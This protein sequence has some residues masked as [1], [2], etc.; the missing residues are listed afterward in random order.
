MSQNNYGNDSIEVLSALEANRRSPELL[1]GDKGVKGARHTIFEIVGNA[2]DEAQSGFGDVIEINYNE[3]TNVVSVR[4]YGRG[5]PLGW[6]EDKVNPDRSAYNWYNIFCTQHA[7]G[8]YKTSY[9]DEL[10]GIQDWSEF[11]S[12]DFPYIYSVGTYGIGASATQQT[13]DFLRVVSIRD[14]ERTEMNFK[15]GLPVV[16]AEYSGEKMKTYPPTVTKSDEPTGTLV[17][18]RPSAD[19]FYETHIG[20]QFLQTICESTAY[21]SKVH[22]VLNVTKADGTVKTYDYPVGTLDDF[23]SKQLGTSSSVLAKPRS[24]SFFNHGTFMTGSM[25]NRQEKIWVAEG[26]ISYAV[27]RDLGNTTAYYNGMRMNA[28]VQFEGIQKALTRFLGEVLPTR[29]RRSEIEGILN[30]VVECKSNHIDYNGADKNNITSGWMRQ[31]V[32]DTLYNDLKEGYTYKTS[33]VLA[34]VNLVK[35]RIENR[36]DDEERKQIVKEIKADSKP[37]ARVSDL[38]AFTPSSNYIKGITLAKKDTDYATRVCNPLE[39][40]YNENFYVEGDSAGGSAEAGRFREFQCITKTTGKPVNSAKVSDTVALSKQFIKSLIQINGAGMYIP[41]MPEESTYDASLEKIDKHII[42]TDADKDGYH[43]RNLI[44]LAFFYFQPEV[45][46][47]GRLFIA[48]APLY[49]V[50][51]TDGSKDFALTLNERDLKIKKSGK[52]VKEISRLKGLG[53][54]ESEDLSLACMNPETRHLVQVLADPYDAELQQ[55]VMEMFGLSS[56]TR[57]S[58]FSILLGVDIIEAE[59]FAK[60]VAKEINADED[61]VDDLDSDFIFV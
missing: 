8:K 48:E 49:E 40:S 57:K 4:D 44:F 36:V 53:E 51:Y 7:G 19:V 3:S 31:L 1:L 42:M 45:I 37:V 56:F 33:N 54:M 2:G 14:G 30:V 39:P 47:R 16:P 61:L 15:D 22:T 17:E 9:D 11:N 13:S 28:G 21:I 46:R 55:N 29:P 34:L 20:Y 24:V 5:M 12:N 52:R 59:N 25:N 38:K 60:E 35:K 32:E 10:R 43:I 41:S 26:Q 27:T 58:I 50:T 6:K 18:W 23:N